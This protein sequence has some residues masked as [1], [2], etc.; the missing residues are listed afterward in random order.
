VVTLKTSGIHY[1][2]MGKIA[3]TRAAWVLSLPNTIGIL[4]LIWANTYFQTNYASVFLY[5]FWIFL[6][7][8]IVPFMGY[9][10]FEYK[11]VWSAEIE[12]AN[13]KSWHVGYNPFREMLIDTNRD[14]KELKK[15]VKQLRAAQDE[16]K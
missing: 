10:V 9:M 4:F 11:R 13:K 6:V 16:G 8:I 12:I 1:F 15:L 14:V 2:N 5:N 3:F 7:C